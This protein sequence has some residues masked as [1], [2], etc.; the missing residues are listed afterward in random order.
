MKK[1]IYDIETVD[2][3]ELRKLQ[4]NRM[5][6]VGDKILIIP[7]DGISE[8]KRMNGNIRIFTEEHKRKLSEAHKGK[9][10][11]KHWKLSEET[12]QKISE[13]KKGNKANLGKHWKWKKKDN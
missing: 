6:I 7:D 1:L 5:K 2:F 4:N 9:K 3:E 10:M 8:H 12:K 13:A 11:N